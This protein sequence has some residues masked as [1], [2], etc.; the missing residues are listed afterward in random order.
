MSNHLNLKGQ[1][2][3][4]LYNA[5][6]QVNRYYTN[7]IFK[8]HGI[9]YPQYLVLRILWDESPVNVKKIV[10][11]LALDTGT[12]SPLLK[13]MEQMD[14]IKRERSEVDQRE[15]FV[16]LTDKSSAMESQLCDAATFVAKASSL[17]LDEIHELNVL[18]EKVIGSFSEENKAK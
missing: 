10:T 7:Q 1:V 3:F 15:V 16:Y 2:C 11:D 12:V 9:T 4:N 18:L 13:R 8:N 14:L 6:R 5:Q 17:T